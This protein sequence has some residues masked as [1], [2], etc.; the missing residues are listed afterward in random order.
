MP[1]FRVEVIEMRKVETS[2][3]VEAA[4]P[5]EAIE[6]AE[7]GD[8]VSEEEG[9]IESVVHREIISEPEEEPEIPGS[10]CIS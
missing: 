10:P 7:I 3:L 4:S 9:D 2:Y 8:T 1:K 6:K 5:K